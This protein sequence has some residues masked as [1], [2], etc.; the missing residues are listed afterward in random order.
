MHSTC[1]AHHIILHLI[2]VIKFDEENKILSSSSCSFSA[3]FPNFEYSPWHS[4]IGLCYSHSVKGQAI[5][6]SEAVPWLRWLVAGL[7]PRRPG[8]ASKSIQWD[9]WWTKWH[10]DGFFSEFFDFPLS[11]SS[12]HGLHFSRN[13]KKYFFHSPLHS[14]SSG[15]G[16]K[17]RK[18]GRSP[19]RRQSHPHNQNNCP[20]N[21]FI[22][23]YITR[24][25][26]TSFKIIS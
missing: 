19:V 10:W 6:L 12:H 26:F 9:L 24:L 15:D 14:S 3:L 20:N 4:V 2:T 16:Q 7:S 11:I 25:L 13:S 23:L 5:Y 8:F 17:V 1:P 18:S 21:C 22:Y